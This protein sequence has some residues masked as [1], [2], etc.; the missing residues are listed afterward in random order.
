MSKKC[1]FFLNEA[2]AGLDNLLLMIQTVQMIV[3][4]NR[5]RFLFNLQ[6]IQIMKT[7]TLILKMRTKHL[8]M[9]VI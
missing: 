6:L 3:T 9:Q 1:C 5:Q 2:N 7:V 8:G 4:L